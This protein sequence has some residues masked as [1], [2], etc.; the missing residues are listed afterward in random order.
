M[1]HFLVIFYCG[2][3]SQKKLGQKILLFILL[4]SFTSP[5]IAWFPIL[6]GKVP[7]NVLTSDQVNLGKD[8]NLFL[9][10]YESISV[11]MPTWFETMAMANILNNKQTDRNLSM[12]RVNLFFIR[13]KLH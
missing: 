4:T 7:S 10:K 12:Q 3:M 11:S 6:Q 13:K 1:P 2:L 8:D 5:Y 9:K